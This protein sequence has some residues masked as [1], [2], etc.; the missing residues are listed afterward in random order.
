MPCLF[1]GYVGHASIA[2]RQAYL[3]QWP[4]KEGFL[5]FPEQ[6]SSRLVRVVLDVI[7]RKDRRRRGEIV[8]R[9]SLVVRSCYYVIRCA[10]F[11]AD[12]ALFRNNPLPR[13][14]LQC[15]ALYPVT[16]QLTFALNL[17]PTSCHRC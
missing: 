2:L 9:E 14:T 11:F 16:L 4:S 15:V 7:V 10:L 12:I 17:L 3:G 1:L 8:L 6:G 5:L 13:L